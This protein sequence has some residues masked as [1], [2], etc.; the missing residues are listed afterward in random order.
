VTYQLLMQ[1]KIGAPE[2][3][4]AQRSG[5]PTLCPAQDSGTP[6][7]LDTW[8]AEHPLSSGD[9]AAVV[10]GREADFAVVLLWRARTSGYVPR[11][12]AVNEGD[13]VVGS[14]SHL[15]QLLPLA[16]VLTPAASANAR[17][18][19]SYASKRRRPEL[20]F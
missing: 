10:R 14:R 7:I 16:A 20:D 9:A 1:G 3:K 12:A 18:L 4:F 6:G 5:C 15:S 19:P 2:G 13:A 8:E 11:H 17:L